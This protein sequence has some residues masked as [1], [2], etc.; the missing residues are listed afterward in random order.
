MEIKRKS[1][2]T[3]IERTR[4]IRINQDDY[5]TW[6]KGYAS[7]SDCMPYLNEDDRTFLLAGITDQ[8]WK[9]AFSNTINNIINDKV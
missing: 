6:K 3:G 4:N 2:L 9:E 8:E 1:P 7:L 5:D